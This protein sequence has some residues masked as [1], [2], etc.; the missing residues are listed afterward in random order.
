MTPMLSLAKTP[1]QA[2]YESTCLDLIRG[3]SKNLVED[4]PINESFTSMNGLDKCVEEINF[5]KSIEDLYGKYHNKNMVRKPSGDLKNEIAYT[6]FK[7]NIDIMK[8]GNFDMS[9]KSAVEMAGTLHND[10]GTQF[11][12]MLLMSEGAKKKSG[13]RVVFN[14]LHPVIVSEL[15]K[16]NTSIDIESKQWTIAIYTF[17]DKH[18]ES[19]KKRYTTL[20]ND[21]NYINEIATIIASIDTPTDYI[22][23]NKNF[24]V[25]IV[26]DQFVLEYE[27]VK[28]M[29][30]TGDEIEM[31]ATDSRNYIVPGQIINVGGIAY[32]YYN[33]IY[34]TKG[35][36][37]NLS[38]MQGANISHPQG[39]KT[40]G[41]MA[42]GSRICTHSGN[43]KTQM[44]ISA[45]NHCNTTSP[46]NRDC[47]EAGSMTYANQCIGASLELLLGDA[48]T[49]PVQAETKALTYQE[50]VA[51]NDGAT[52]AQYLTYIRNRMKE[53][54]ASEPTTDTQVETVVNQEIEYPEFEDGREYNIGDIVLDQYINPPTLRVLSNDNQWTDYIPPI[55]LEETA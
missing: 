16:E 52:K 39:Q 23:E 31:K 50:F 34:S 20:Y 49:S 8:I 4:K 7:H 44:G 17:K 36:A 10:I 33:T 19:F 48:F 5:S 27:E 32:P 25:D 46:L 6:E 15:K 54:M 1:M 30:D 13:G 35:L 18:E 29:K 11:Y 41:G 24:K 53:K 40:S 2:I 47:M 55:I 42:G 21:E 14:P 22:V 51:E 37:W 45:L 3:L 43:S 9:I 12:G 28:R 26:N 38:P